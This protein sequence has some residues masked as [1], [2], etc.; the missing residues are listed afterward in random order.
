[1]E[2]AI[3]N[4]EIIKRQDAS[5][6]IE[7]RG[8]QFGDGV[9]EVIRV[10]NGKMF[11]LAEHLQRFE[12]SLK[13]IG[14]TLPYSNVQIAG[15]LEELVAKDGLSNGMIYMQITRGVS[16][17]N[18]AFPVDTVV[19]VLTA[20]SKEV[21]RPVAQMKSGVRTVLVEDIRW[22]R[23]DIKSLNL[24]GNLLA[25]QKASESGCFEAIQ[26]RGQNVTEGSTS[27]V[28]MVK[29]G[30]VITHESDNLILKGITK[31]VLLELCAKNNFPVEE[32]TF[33][34]EELSVADEVFLTSTTAEVMPI[35]EIAEKKVSSGVPGPVTR[36]L[37]ALFSEEIEKQCGVLA[38]KLNF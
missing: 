9:Y 18:H 31:D 34:L 30:V 5:V 27:N 36:K 1:M 6:D 7:D 26:H 15:M 13:E 20:Y 29:K 33:N 28:F 19:P 10:F 25:K 23:C 24:L 35:V 4:G 22:L 38:E 16:P 17:R 2:H 8:Y 12:R 37:Q 14:I 3:V 32:R 11:T 21:E